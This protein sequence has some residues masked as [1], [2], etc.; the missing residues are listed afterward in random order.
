MYSFLAS[1]LRTEPNAEL[2]NQLTN[3]ESDD[4]PIGKSIKILSK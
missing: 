1:L 3:L 4:S 2:V